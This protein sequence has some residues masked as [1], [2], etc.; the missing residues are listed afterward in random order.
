MKPIARTLIVLG[1]VAAHGLASAGPR[2]YGHSHHRHHH[3]HHRG[4]GLGGLVLG[5]AV[6]VPLIALANQAERDRQPEVVYVPPPAPLPPQPVY[7][8][9][10]AVY[11]PARPAPVIYPRNGQGPDQLEADSRECNRWATTQQA[12]M[13]DAGVFQRAVEACMDGRGYTLR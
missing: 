6:A 8:P 5:L 1:L 13:S 11:A 7:A 9:P 2:H 12:A 4:A 10:Q 3:H